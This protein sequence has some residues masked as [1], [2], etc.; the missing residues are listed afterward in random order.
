MFH[1]LESGNYMFDQ[2][3]FKAYPLLTALD[4]HIHAYLA[5]SKY[6]FEA[7]RDHAMHSYLDIAEHE[8]ELGFLA[9]SGQLS[10]LR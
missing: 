3:A 10:T 1:F 9:F 8:L 2:R 5:G 7:L 6:G 4:F